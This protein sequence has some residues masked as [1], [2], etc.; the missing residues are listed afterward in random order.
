MLCYCHCVDEKKHNFKPLKSAQKWQP[1]KKGMIAS[2][3]VKLFC[4]Y[5]PGLVYYIKNII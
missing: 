4:L 5:T 3:I 1:V 2:S